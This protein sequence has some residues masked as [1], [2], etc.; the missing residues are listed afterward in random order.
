MSESEKIELEWKQLQVEE[1]REKIQNRRDERDRMKSRRERQLLDFQNGER[2]TRQMQTV[3]KHRKGGRDNRFLKGNDVNFSIIRN[4]Y[5]TGLEVIMCTR[6]RKEVAKPD[7]RDRK[8]NP[9]LYAEQLAEWRKWDDLP[10][11]NS[12]SGGKIFEIIPAAA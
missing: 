4:T 1:L 11:D 3:C 7:P 5:P 9:T 10:T 8:K 2:L 12:P 6:C